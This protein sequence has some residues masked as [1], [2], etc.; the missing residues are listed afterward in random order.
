MISASFTT[1]LLIPCQLLI[2]VFLSFF[3]NVIFL[4]FLEENRS[5]LGFAPKPRRK[6]RFAKKTKKR[7]NKKSQ[8][9][10]NKSTR[11][12]KA[13]KNI[14]RKTAT[15]YYICFRGREIYLGKDRGSG[16]L[17]KLLSRP[18]MEYSLESLH[19]GEDG[20]TKCKNIM[21]DCGPINDQTGKEVLGKKLVEYQ[22][23]MDEAR[24]ANNYTMLTILEREYA[25]YQAQW[26][27]AVNLHGKSRKLDD[28]Q[29][30][31]R[32]AISIAISRTLLKIALQ[33]KELSQHLADF[34][35]RGRRPHYSR[36]SEYAWTT[37]CAA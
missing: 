34:I 11:V 10:R 6:K 19:L 30:R 12:E 33:D 36:A 32:K 2:G 8:T 14:Y 22:E 37:E 1:C 17:I 7:R 28:A 23:K 15:G 16:H 18:G 9:K 20:K 25:P 27:E 24:K 4:I 29:E 21:T 3:V 13:I 35:K 5:A 26:D 31:M